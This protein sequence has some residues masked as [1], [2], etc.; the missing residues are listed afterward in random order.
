MTTKARITERYDAGNLEA[1]SIL[2]GDPKR[3]PGL[4]QE[5]ADIVLTR[6]AQ[7]DDAEAGPLFRKVA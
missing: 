4:P 5:W 6:A 1:A 7:P 2:A 3:Y